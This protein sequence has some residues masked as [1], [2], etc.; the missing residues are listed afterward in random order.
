MKL[1][2]LIVILSIT[3]II[4]AQSHS[5][6]SYED[7]LVALS[8]NFLHPEYPEELKKEKLTRFESLLHAVLLNTESVDYPFSQL[9]QVSKLQPP[10]KRF[11]LFTWFTVHPWGY[12]AHGMVQITDSKRKKNRVITLSEPTE[13]IKSISNKSLDASHWLGMV[14]YDLIPVIQGK[15]TYYVLLGFHGNDGLT[16]KKFID[17]ITV[18]SNGT[19]KFG[20]PVFIQDQRT[21]HRVIFEYRANAKMSLRYNE[22][23]KMIVFDHLSPENPSLK[24]QY[25]YYVPD[26]SY[27]AF[28]LEKGKWIYKPD[29]FTKNESENKGNEGKKYDLILPE[30]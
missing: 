1:A 23:N 10:N 3:G 21:S 8:T 16:H 6:A 7:S 20:A 26:F 15:N 18:S 2:K 4:H 22:K 30:K 13:T 28:K 27:D 9:T 12:K 14:Y 19:I 5:L 17:V 11:R 29:I 25:Q 24:G